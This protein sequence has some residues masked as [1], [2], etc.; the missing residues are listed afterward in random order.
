MIKLIDLA[1]YKLIE[2]ET[3]NSKTYTLLWWGNEQKKVKTLKEAIE[4]IYIQERKYLDNNESFEKV[5]KDD[6]TN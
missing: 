1:G 4:Y 5:W 2:N 3:N 6:N